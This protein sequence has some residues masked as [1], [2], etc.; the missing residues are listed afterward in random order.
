MEEIWKSVIKF[1]GYYEVSNYGN[2]RSVDR[3]I[4]R[5]GN[6]EVNYKS[7]LLKLNK[8]TDGYPQAILH[9]NNKFYTRK[10]HYLVAKMFILNPENKPTVNH[11]D[12][13]KTNNF[14]WNLEW[15]TVR[16]NVQHSYDTGLKFAIKG[17]KNVLS[18]SVTQYDMNLNKIADFG[19][20]LEA[21][22]IT[23]ISR[24]C[25]SYCANG[26]TRWAGGYIWKY[27]VQETV[28]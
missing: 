4:I 6:V 25:I 26:I 1:E 3:T 17:A 11:K 2:V 14:D 15:A 27:N 16:E 9:K 24:R 10:V 8:D 22:R 20:T 18:K 7:K 28:T 12:G 23:G 19:S 13:I 21:Q 5:K